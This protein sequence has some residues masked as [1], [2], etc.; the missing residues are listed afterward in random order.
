M[1]SFLLLGFV[2]NLKLLPV[3]LISVLGLCSLMHFV[4]MLVMVPKIVLS[5]RLTTEFSL[6]LV[7]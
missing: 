5:E 3:F 6:F 4:C 1:Q 2:H 7:Q